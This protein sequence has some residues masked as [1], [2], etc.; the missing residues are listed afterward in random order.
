MWCTTYA[1]YNSSSLC[2]A[3]VTMF[4]NLQLLGATAIEDKLQ[5][6]RL[7]TFSRYFCFCCFVFRAI[8]YWFQAFL[9]VAAKVWNA[10][11]DHIFSVSSTDSFCHRQKTVL[12]QRSFCSLHLSGPCS[13]LA[14]GVAQWLG[15]RSIAGWLFLTCAR[16]VVDWWPLCW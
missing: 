5:D 12:F 13:C 15:R 10:L 4:Q 7:E 1:N 11:P 3:F 9:V 6:V 14:G 16:S 2:V 8:T